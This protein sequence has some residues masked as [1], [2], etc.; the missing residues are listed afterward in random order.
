MIDFPFY[1][2]S[3]N[4]LQEHALV[5][6]F[7][8]GVALLI[9]FYRSRFEFQGLVALLKTK[10]GIKQ[11]KKFATPLPKKKDLVGKKIFLIS[12][13][14]FLVL[15]FF[16]LLDM[17]FGFSFFFALSLRL[18][19]AL[20]FLGVCVSI[21]F[22]RQIKSASYV[23]VYVGFLGMLF[24]LVLLSM[25]LYQ[26]FF[27][28]SAP[29]MFAPVLPGISI[30]G[31]PFKLPLFEG[32]I[33]LLVV[34]VIHEFSHGV[35][36][37]SYKVPIKSSGFVMFGPLP[38]AFVEPDEKKLKNASSKAQLSVFAAGPFSNILLA[39]FLFILLA[40]FS[41]LSVS[42]YEPSGVRIDGFVNMDDGRD[43]SMLDEGDVIKSVNNVS[44]LSSYELVVFV[45]NLSPGD[46][47]S[48]MIDDDEKLVVLGS[49][50]N[51]ES[52]PFI[53]VF[54]D[55]EVS[56]T[57]VVS[58]NKFF[59][60]AYFWLIGNPF[61]SSLNNN[62]GLLWLIFVLSFGIGIVNLL[63][64]G[65]LDGGR[66]IFLVM[67]KKFGEK[68]ASKYLTLL[69]KFLFFLVLILVF[70]PIIRALI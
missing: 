2:M 61:S 23:G 28:P 24:M 64:V 12:S 49:D 20:S 63:P 43:L 59:S 4:W 41:L 8:L 11:M 32:L 29:P 34:V 67:K 17:I 51:N 14:S 68:K 58:N 42:L 31:T 16:L 33:S 44:V 21:V 25:G 70:I 57:T 39:G 48:F 66:M 35:V 5:I 52:R 27:D 65:P 13:Y 69:S 53:G 38:G 56:G 7:Y 3:F 37:K 55:T 9:Y 1:F 19:L 46:V 6:L 60:Y 47:V 40:L 62:L 50:P 26:L 54:L 22:F 30:P 18:L 15:V 10:L 36:S 45:Q